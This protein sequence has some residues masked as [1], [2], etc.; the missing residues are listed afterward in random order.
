MGCRTVVR[1]GCRWRATGTSSKPVIATSCGTRMPRWPSAWITPSAVWSLAQR[2]ARGSFLLACLVVG[3]VGSSGDVAEAFVS[4]VVRQVMDQRS[5]PGPVVAPDVD[6]RGCGAAGQRHDRDHVGQPCDP[7]RRQH[8]VVEDQ[9]IRLAGEGADP[10]CNV[11][12]VEP[13]RADEQIEAA[14]L[15][16]HFDAAIDDVDEEEAL[17]LTLEVSL[18]ALSAENDADHF[19]QPVGQS[20]RGA[21]GHEA[22]LANGLHDPVSCLNAWSAEAA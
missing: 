2:I 1:G 14:A 18:T 20:P 10:L 12:V 21:V 11:V 9:A 3:A 17:V 7:D 13:D 15:R 16:P 5:D 6:G 4:V 22:E 8:P 19:F